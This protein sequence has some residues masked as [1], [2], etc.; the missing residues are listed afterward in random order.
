MTTRRLPRIARETYAGTVGAQPQ[1]VPRGELVTMVYAAN[2]GGGILTL[3]P[4]NGST[5]LNHTFA[6][7]D[8][9]AVDGR[10]YSTIQVKAGNGTLY[11]VSLARDLVGGFRSSGGAAP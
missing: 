7:G 4:R 3:N 11:Y 10:Q 5:P 8:I 1:A 9:F 2:G 6:N